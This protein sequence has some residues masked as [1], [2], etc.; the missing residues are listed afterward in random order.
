VDA[1]RRVTCGGIVYAAPA[2]DAPMQ[3][4]GGKRLDAQGP[5]RRIA[6]TLLLKPQVIST[7]IRDSRI[8]KDDHR[9]SAG[10]PDEG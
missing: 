4:G 8:F 2:I 5:A 10:A 9:P 7:G 3:D 6:R 1:Q